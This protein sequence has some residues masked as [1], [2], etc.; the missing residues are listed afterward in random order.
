[1]KQPI[2]VTLRPDNLLWLRTHVQTTGRRSLSE[3]LDEI[4]TEIRAGDRAGAA[5]VR[6]VVGSVRIPA[7]DAALSA[8][9]K[10]LR[11]LFRDSISQSG[12]RL[13]RK[14]SRRRGRL[15]TPKHA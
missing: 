2:S 9:S 8:A 6:S 5:E 1:M 12:R 15:A 7:S 11:A 10:R 3:A 14:R 13:D 4:L